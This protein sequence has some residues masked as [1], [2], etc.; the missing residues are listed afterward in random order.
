MR[1]ISVSLVQVSDREIPLRC[2]KLNPCQGD[3]NQFHTIG[4]C[5]QTPYT[6]LWDTPHNPYR[7]KYDGKDSIPIGN[8]AASTPTFVNT[9]TAS[10]GY[11][12]LGTDPNLTPAGNSWEPIAFV[13][14]NANPGLN[15]NLNPT[16]PDSLETAVNL[17]SQF[18]EIAFRRNRKNRRSLGGG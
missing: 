17:D 4:Q 13:D 12:N 14:N 1:I 11:L 8:S 16:L 2:C 5:P 18:N 15:S 3:D 9:D 6:N 10:A 7:M